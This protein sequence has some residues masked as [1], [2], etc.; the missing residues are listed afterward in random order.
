MRALEP[1]SFSRERPLLS[2]LSRLLRPAGLR[3]SADS[4]VDP[5]RFEEVELLAVGT[6]R[7]SLVDSERGADVGSSEEVAREFDDEVVV[8]K[9]EDDGGAGEAGREDERGVDAAE[10]G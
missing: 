9:V 4:R 6:T 10:L 5:E 2:S 8:D 1:L 3:T 7:S